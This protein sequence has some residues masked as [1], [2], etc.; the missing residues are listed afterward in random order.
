MA[1]TVAL[2]IEFFHSQ[3]I[4]YRRPERLHHAM[5]DLSGAA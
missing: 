3:R 2:R 1:L 5:L 4:K